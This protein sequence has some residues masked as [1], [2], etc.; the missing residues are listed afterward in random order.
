MFKYLAI[1]A[2]LSAPC[3]ALD[4]SDVETINWE[5]NGI[6]YRTDA[7]GYGQTDYWATPD[8]M[9]ANGF[10]DCEDFAIAKYFA[11]LDA[12]ADMA[13]L[14]I[15]YVDSPAGAHMVL[16]YSDA[17]GTD[18]VLDNASRYIREVSR[19]SDLK[20]LYRFNSTAMQVGGVKLD[21]AILSNWTDLLGRMPNNA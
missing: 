18:W 16:L 17:N 2:A 10:G 14:S 20:E 9:A 6:E 11:L 4:M 1:L 19:R 21:V 12:G 3:A 8:E 15:A 13:D 7:D 5:I